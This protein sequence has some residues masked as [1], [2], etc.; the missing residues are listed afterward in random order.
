MGA[1]EVRDGS[2]KGGCWRWHPDDSCFG[3]S[4][5]NNSFSSS[6]EFECNGWIAACES[7]PT[8]EWSLH[9]SGDGIRPFRRFL[10]SWNEARSAPLPPPLAPLLLAL[11][12]QP[13]RAP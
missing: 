5:G 6:L 11:P 1:K 4:L 2:L 10:P 12:P 3:R 7:S 8:S 9:S 13:Q